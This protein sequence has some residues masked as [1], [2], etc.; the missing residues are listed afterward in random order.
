ML[1][2]I[3]AECLLLYVSALST[4]SIATLLPVESTEMS[5]RGVQGANS[6]NADS[7]NT[8]SKVIGSSVQ[9]VKHRM[10]L[11]VASTAH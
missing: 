2:F 4:V 9:V 7:A 6:G 11:Q 3:Q 10:G 5:N 1:K 8:C